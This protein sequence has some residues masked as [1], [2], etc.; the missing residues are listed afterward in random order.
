MNYG[1]HMEIVIRKNQKIYLWIYLTYRDN[2]EFTA[3][4]LDLP[5]LTQI[6]RGKIKFTAV[7]FILPR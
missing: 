5:R 4:N 2:S 6:Y 7:N 1:V 3:V